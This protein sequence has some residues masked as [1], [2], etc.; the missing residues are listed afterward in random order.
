MFSISFGLAWTEMKP[1]I[2]YKADTKTLKGHN[3]NFGQAIAGSAFFAVNSRSCGLM[4]K[5]LVFGGKGC[6]LESCQ[7]HR[8][9]ALCRPISTVFREGLPNILALRGCHAAAP[10]STGVH[11]GI[12][13]THVL[14]PPFDPSLVRR[15]LGHCP[16]LGAQ[17][18][19]R[20]YS[21]ISQ[22]CG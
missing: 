18:A 10:V 3:W 13:L 14:L 1:T 19:V 4:D 22:N 6:R 2:G 15:F 12:Q 5:A 20:V 16:S 9:F 21:A 8:I 11:R 17:H 7:D